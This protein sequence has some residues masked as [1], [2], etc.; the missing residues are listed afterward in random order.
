M[1]SR[2]LYPH[3]ISGFDHPVAD[4][5]RN[6]AVPHGEVTGAQCATINRHID[7]LV[8]GLAVECSVRLRDRPTG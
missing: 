4:D 2:I 3:L 1:T 7:V 6:V 5:H 8:S